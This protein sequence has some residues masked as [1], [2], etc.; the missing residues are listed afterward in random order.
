MSYLPSLTVSAVELGAVVVGELDRTNEV[1]SSPP[2]SRIYVVL[3]IL[4]IPI[5]HLVSNLSDVSPGKK[6]WKVRISTVYGGEQVGLWLLR[7]YRK[8]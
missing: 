4:T 2:C 5:I 3:D 8:E 7:D 1:R 6:A